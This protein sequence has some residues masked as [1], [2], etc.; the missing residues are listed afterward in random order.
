M[1]LL[2]RAATVTFVIAMIGPIAVVRAQGVPPVVH[3]VTDGL[4]VSYN[5]AIPTPHEV[6]GHHIGWRHTEPHQVVEY[7]REVASSSE[8]VTVREHARSHEGRPL[9]HAVVTS[10]DNHSALEQIRTD[11]LGL[12]DD[13]AS[14]GNADLRDMPAVVLMSYSVHGNE[15][16][17]T[18]A[19]LLLLYH[20]AAGRG[21]MIDQVLDSTVVIIEPMLN[22]DG[23]ARF[24]T[25]ANRNRGRATVTDPQDREHSEPWPGGRTNHYWFDLNRDYI[26]VRHPE[27]RGR[28]A[29]FHHWRPQVVT[30]FH[31][32]GSDRS[33]FF[34]PG[35]P[36]RKNP[37]TPALNQEITAAF[38]RYHARALDRL[39]TGYYS[40]E[41]FDDF[42]YGKW[43]TY[44]DVNGAIGILFEQASSRALARETDRGELHYS[45]T[46][47]NQ[48]ATSLSTLEAAADNRM[49]LLKYQRDFY[50]E[51]A[52][53]G[54]REGGRLV[55]AGD[56]LSRLREF[57]ELM[58]RHRIELQGLTRRL[59]AGNLTFEPGRSLFIP[60]RQPQQRLIDALFERRTEFADSVFY[61]VSAWTLPLAY[62]LRLSEVSRTPAVDALEPW[63]TDSTSP[64]SSLSGTDA[65]VA[66]CLRWND[67]YGARTLNELQRAG[68]ETRVATR[69]FLAST[70][71]GRQTFAP[72]TIVIT[73]GRLTADSLRSVLQQVSLGRTVEFEA[74]A[75]SLTPGGPD[76]GSPSNR[77]LTS[78]R[79]AI[80]TGDGASAYRAGEAWHLLSEMFEAPVSLLDVQKVN[81][82]DLSR[83]S[84]ILMAGGSYEGLSSDAIRTWVADGGHLVATG[85]ASLWAIANELIDADTLS[86]NL[87]AVVTGLPYADRSKA[88]GAQAIGGAI[89]N[90]ALD[91]T[92]PVAYGLESTLPVFRSGRHFVSKP[93]GNTA[94]VASY[95]G[96]PL[97][98]GYLPDRVRPLILE[99]ASVVTRQW[100]RGQIIVFAENPAYRGFWLG[101]NRMLLNAIFLAEAL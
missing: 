72:G 95:T 65:A 8:R 24:T 83:Y 58:Q 67:F 3:M 29:L 80:L 42:Y 6:L 31:E 41:T 82:A 63:T 18:E 85:T 12:S 53:T 49:R 35:I 100:G 56:D 90:T 14:L 44:P 89:L 79:I 17:G 57:A 62:D 51:G 81:T 87:D 28:L 43:S 34:Q 61:D 52:V 27:T 50:A 48:F 93:R 99:A 86:V 1:Q 7:F 60:F 16:S 91:L 10:V 26:P 71:R 5:Q 96:D 40:E 69:E 39:P 20:L 97:L 78:R 23:R 21:S 68:V 13:P 25:W 46:V 15:A 30:D 77:L 32:M 54:R 45:T 73:R 47:R 92:H 98:S 36:S 88:R 75:T 19:A 37:N 64:T 55:T 22:P 11:N 2:L 101:T 59:E 9:I 70:Q 76:L 74:L 38:A 66:Y 84:S 33:Y 4:D 94:V